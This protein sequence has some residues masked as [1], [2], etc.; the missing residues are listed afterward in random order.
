MDYNQLANRATVGFQNPDENYVRALYYIYE[1]EN[2]LLRH[3]GNYQSYYN[4]LM[5]SSANNHIVNLPTEFVGVAGR[6]EFDGVPLTELPAFRQVA[7]NQNDLS[8][9]TGN[10]YWY[11]IINR[12]MYLYP[13]PND[14]TKRL[15]ASLNVVPRED[16]SAIAEVSTIYIQGTVSGGEY[17][18]VSSPTI[19]WCIYLT[20]DGTGS[21]PEITGKT[22][23]QVVLNSSM[24]DAQI[25][26]AIQTALDA[27]RGLTVTGSTATVTITQD[28]TGNVRQLTNID[29]PFLMHTTIAGQSA[30]TSPLI[31]LAYHDLL[32]IYA[33]AQ[34][35]L[36][37]GLDRKYQMLNAEWESK[38]VRAKYE[39]SKEGGLNPA[40]T[41]DELGSSSM[42][43]L[44]TRPT[45][46]NYS[47]TV[48][49]TVNIRRDSET[50][51]NVTEVTVT[52]NWGTY[53]IVQVL[54]DSDPPQQ[55]TADV[56][57]I[58]ANSFKVD[59]GVTYKSGTI[60]YS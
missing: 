21:D 42:G 33:R 10:P 43:R 40:D 11:F 30:I 59:F 28:A 12:Q 32:P 2:R 1:A 16:R 51:S 27:L 39:I 8:W 54:D 58:D 31:N 17:F 29:S 4:D 22:A 25:A 18:Y 23:V 15:S 38:L 53:P 52:H 13:E 49:E 50:F 60:I 20:Y 24:T 44:N 35:C 55:F 9:N 5:V 36:D 34:I 14:T 19:D 47:Y 45:S 57:Y 7:L 48:T 46:R 3:T 41:I 6:I 37:I 26:T 56:I